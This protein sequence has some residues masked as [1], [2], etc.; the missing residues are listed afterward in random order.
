M[1]EPYLEMLS[2]KIT[3]R[4]SILWRHVLEFLQNDFPCYA[5]YLMGL[6]DTEVDP[7]SDH[8][9]M[10]AQAEMLLEFMAAHDTIATRLCVSAKVVRRCR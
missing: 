4:S 2:R 10:D 8:F 7:E 5:P 6:G 9:H 3:P 1:A